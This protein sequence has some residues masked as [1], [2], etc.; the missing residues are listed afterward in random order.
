LIQVGRVGVAGHAAADTQVEVAGVGPGGRVHGP[1]LA[2]EG[3]AGYQPA[4]GQGQ[5]GDLAGGEL[6]VEGGVD[7][8]G[9]RVQ[10]GHAAPG[11]AVDAGEGAPIHSE[12]PSLATFGVMLAGLALTTAPSPIDAEPTVGTAARAAQRPTE[13]RMARSDGMSTRILTSRPRQ[14]DHAVA[15]R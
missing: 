12:A 3:A 14:A 4:A 11:H 8:P 1:Q 13:T 7:G 10:L 2:R 9:G 15:L 5:I 6:G